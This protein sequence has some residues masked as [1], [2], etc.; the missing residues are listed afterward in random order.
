MTHFPAERHGCYYHNRDTCCWLCM[1]RSW[2][3]EIRARWA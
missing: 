1:V 3:A 2:W